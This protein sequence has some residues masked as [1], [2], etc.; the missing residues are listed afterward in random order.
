MTAA[1]FALRRLVQPLAVVVALAVPATAS[2]AHGPL[3]R[4][5]ADTKVRG[6]AVARSFLGFSQEYNLARTWLGTPATD[7]NPLLVTLFRQL[8]GYGSGPPVL[9]FGGG[10]TDNA[11]WNPSLRPRPPGIYFGIDYTLMVPL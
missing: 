6:P 9:R 3:V 4:A 8:A 11:W 10:S 5:D 1:M 2:A 7:V